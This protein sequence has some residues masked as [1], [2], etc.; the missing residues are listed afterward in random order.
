LFRVAPHS[1]HDC[2]R[3][4]PDSLFSIGVKQIGQ[5]DWLCLFRV[6]AVTTSASTG[7]RRIRPIASALL[8]FF[9][10]RLYLLVINIVS[11]LTGPVS[12]LSIWASAAFC[13]DSRDPEAGGEITLPPMDVPGRSRILQATDDQRGHFALMQGPKS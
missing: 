10:L 5:L 8:S 2:F 13:L 9:L 12:R 4:P 1:A 3:P 11:S 6:G 7:N